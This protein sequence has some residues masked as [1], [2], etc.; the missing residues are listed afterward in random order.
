MALGRRCRGYT[1]LHGIYC[2]YWGGM[3]FSVQGL[4]FRVA[5]FGGF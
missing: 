4:V 2:N 3:R 5:V 1:A